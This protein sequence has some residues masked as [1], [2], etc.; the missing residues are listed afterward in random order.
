M[1]IMGLLGLVL[2][3]VLVGLLA[4][5]Q[6]A[7]VPTPAAAPLAPAGAGAPSAAARPSAAAIAS[8][9][10]EALRAAMP[11]RVLPGEAE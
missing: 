5:R 2:A 10:Q 9:Y 6:L 4:K 1:R 8:Q 11:P 3:L 7:A